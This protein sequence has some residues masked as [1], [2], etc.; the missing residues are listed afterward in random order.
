MNLTPD[1][2]QAATGCSPVLAAQ[3]ALHFAEAGRLWAINTPGR[4]ACF[5]AQVGHES[6]GFAHRVEL[7]SYSAE[8]LAD[9]GRL[10][11]PRSRWAAAAKQAARLAR[12]PE[13][14]ANFV[15]ADRNGNGDETSGDGWRFK[16]RGLIQL[17]GRAN[18][19]EIGAEVRR[20]LPSAPDFEA[21]PDAVEQPRWAA[22]SAGAFWHL[23]GLNKLAD[24]GQ[25]TAIGRA[26]NG[27]GIG[28]G[29]R[30]T[31]YERARRVLVA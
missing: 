10:N 23:K 24:A 29:D 19:R 22:L 13:A 16:G 28:H 7:L 27:G 12:N 6:Q 1:Q 9:L 2:L 31:R 21:N 30:V 18:Y 4:W 26:I 14:L 11:G 5:L 20:A 25:I 15:Y 17:T 3:Y 8:R